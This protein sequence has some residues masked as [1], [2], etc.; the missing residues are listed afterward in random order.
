M[1]YRP[2]FA[3]PT[4]SPNIIEEDFLALFDPTII[5]IL[6]QN[7][8]ALQIVNDIPLQFQRDY[9][10]TIKAIKLNVVADNPI[11]IAFKDAFNNPISESDQYIDAI[12]SYESNPSAAFPGSTPVIFEPDMPM[13][14]G[15]TMFVSFQNLVNSTTPLS[16]SIVFLG[17]KVYPA[18]LKMQACE[19]R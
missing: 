17:I 2:Q 3:N 14:A 19:R 1:R 6:G 16:I 15:A 4:P 13:P 7:L 5:P 18:G 10:F 8:G 12:S 11:G 9:H